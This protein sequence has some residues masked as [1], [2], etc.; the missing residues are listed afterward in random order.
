MAAN[1]LKILIIDDNQD[2]LISLKAVLRDAFPG[3]TVFTAVNGPKGIDLAAA[4]NPDVILLDIAMPGMDGF[5]VCRRLKADKYV[6]DIPVLFLTAVKSDRLSRIKALEVGGEAFLSKPID[7]AELTAQIRVLAKI[8]EANEFKRE[9][10][11]RL[12]A[13]VGK[14]TRELEESR[15]AALNLLEDLKAENEARKKTEESLRESEAAY[16]EL[17]EN[18]ND[19]V[20]KTDTQGVIT[21]VSPQVKCV[22]GYSHSELEGQNF[23]SL[24][25][26]DE[27]DDLVG[28]FQDVLADRIHTSD[29][30][31]R[32]K[33]GEYRFARSSSRPIMKDGKVLGIQGIAADITELKKS[34]DALK[35]SEMFLQ[36]IVENIPDMI[37]V[38]DAEKLRFVRLNRAGEELLGYSREYLL[39]K[40]DYDF[41]PREQADFFTTKDREVIARGKLVEILEEEIDTKLNGKRILHTKKIPLVDINGYPQ[42]LLGIS[43]DVTDRKQLEQDLRESE[44]TNRLLIEEAPI[45]VGVLQEEKLVFVNPA[46]LDIF[47]YESKDEV[48]GR[49][50]EDFISPEDQELITKRRKDRLLGKKLPLSYEV[51]GLKKN[52]ASFDL[53]MW[54][55]IIEFDGMPAIMTFCTDRTEQKS[56]RDQLLQAQKMEAVGTLAGG[57]A[58]DFNNILQIALGYSDLI[59]MDEKLDNS[60]RDSLHQISEA[61]RRGAELVKRLL[62]FSRR[63]DTEPRQLDLNHQIKQAK[64]LLDRTIP[65]MIAIGLMLEEELPVIN[66]DPVQVEQILMN[67]AINA[68]DAMPMEGGKLTISTRH[69]SLGEEYCSKHIGA[70]PGSYA[71]MSVSDTG[72]GMTPETLE[73]IFEP[74]FTTKSQGKGTGLGLAMVFGIVQQHE[75]YI[76]CES[77]QG[78]GT[79]F[80]IYFPVALGEP[81]KT[82]PD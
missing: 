73:H 36:Q 57:V 6:R 10:K 50:V 37:F 52:G 72:C 2:N 25:H 78:S 21:Y 75:G 14:R 80:E 59:L 65:K 67:L 61:S 66:A 11:N 26:P 55:R 76:S 4:E 1:K 41:F 81:E 54:P 82:K 16:R 33:S 43:E 71:M 69:V 60:V 45:G 20:F 79:T 51:K 77:V 5:E 74:F 28:N 13:L 42:F 63:G 40:N 9:E 34:E 62:A 3:V 64:A 12:A 18:L 38:K 27:V 56:L 32:S 49:P 35:E 53:A 46:F 68:R 31:L 23:S 15:T 17:V 48:L 44:K 7:E 30:R 58:H 19:V 8:K 39:G 22:L 29:Y 47:G 70:K 24:A